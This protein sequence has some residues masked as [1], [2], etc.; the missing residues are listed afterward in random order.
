MSKQKKQKTVRQWFA[1]ILC[2]CIFLVNAGVMDTVLAKDGRNR[3]RETTASSSDAE[4]TTEEIETTAGETEA[5][6]IQAA[7]SSNSI[8]KSDPSVATDS[9]ALAFAI[10][11]AGGNWNDAEW[12]YDLNGKKAVMLGEGK[13][14]SDGPYMVGILNPRESL[15]DGDDSAPWMG[16]RED[17]IWHFVPRDEAPLDPHDLANGENGEYTIYTEVKSSGQAEPEKSYLKIDNVEGQGDSIKNRDLLL[18]TDSNAASIFKVTRGT[19]ERA[20]R[21]SIVAEHGNKEIALNLYSGDTGKGFGAYE[22]G[23]WES[24]W[25]WLAPYKEVEKIEAVNHAG[26]VINLFDYWL[27]EKEDSDSKILENEE[28]FETPVED[29]EKGINKKHVLKFGAYRNGIYPNWNKYYAGDYNNQG[30]APYTGIVGS[31]LG[32]DGYPQLSGY[33]EAFPDSEKTKLSDY[34]DEKYTESLSYLFNPTDNHEG[35]ESHPNVDGLL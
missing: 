16:D 11:G 31:V 1:W 10:V 6:T 9:D 33:K 26:T 13:K 28:I 34:D 15:T 7:S 30:I 23:N 18:A 20:G 8:I 12:D 4:P 14:I 35:K 17:V 25:L 32:A 5:E 21:F 19:G 2:I 22:Y 27:T 3:I 29:A 24:E